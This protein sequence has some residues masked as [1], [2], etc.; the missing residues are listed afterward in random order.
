MGSTEPEAKQPTIN[1][2]SNRIR[3]G[4]AEVKHLVNLVKNFQKGLH[5][6]GG[7][8]CAG[9]LPAR[10]LPPPPTRLAGTAGL[11]SLASPPPP[12]H[13]SRCLCLLF[14]LRLISAW[15]CLPRWPCQS[16]MDFCLFLTSRGA[17]LLTPS[18]V[19][20][21]Q[22]APL[23]I[24]F[25]Y[26]WLFTEA[27]MWDAIKPK[28]DQSGFILQQV[29]PFYVEAACSPHDCVVFSRSSNSLKYTC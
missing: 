4:T 14:A 29:R 5:R 17:E 10:P 12:L 9:P 13:S 7:C 25:I 11:S 3:V 23:S 8:S 27:P 21:L 24:H 15:F 16:G 1:I 18:C 19:F 26:I 22:K 28:L 20:H 2:K 6:T